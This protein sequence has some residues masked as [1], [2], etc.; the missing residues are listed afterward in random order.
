M[1]S[2]LTRSKENN[3]PFNIFAEEDITV[4]FFHLDPMCVVWH[5]N[6]VNYF[7]IGRRVLL[8][9]IKYGYDEMEKSGF[10]FP[11]VDLSVR[12][13]G[14]LKFMDKARIK[15]ILMEYENCLQIKYEIRNVETGLLATKGLTTQMAY[16]VKAGESCF[17][18]PEILIEKVEAL[19]GKEK[20]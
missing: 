17:V 1:R 4:E 9:K 10:M 20:P 14:F 12:Y 18:C 8:E 7:E 2:V 15:A 16:N 19:I 3:G 11:V 13:L 5:G 6:Y